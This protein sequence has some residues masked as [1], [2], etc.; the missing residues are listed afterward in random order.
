MRVQK[1]SG[2]WSKS[3]ATIK[4][5]EKAIKKFADKYNQPGNG[6]GEEIQKFSWLMSVD[7]ET[8]RI[9]PV[10]INPHYTLFRFVAD[11]RFAVMG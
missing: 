2:K 9:I 10:V 6:V 4:S 3:Y 8:G 7:E 5:A 11:N 1:F